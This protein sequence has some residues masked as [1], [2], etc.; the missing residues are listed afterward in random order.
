MTENSSVG[1]TAELVGVS[2]VMPV[3][4]DV[5][6]VKAAVMSLLEQDYAGPFEVAIAVGPSIDGTNEL[7]DELSRADPRIRVI[8]NPVGSTPAG[9]NIAIGATTYPIVVR[10][11]AH[12]VLPRDYARIAVEAITRTGAD[13]V[14]GIMDAQG[15]TASRSASAERRTTSAAPRVQRTPYTSVCSAASRSSVSACSTSASNVARTGNSTDASVPPAVSS[16]SPLSFGS[17]TGHVPGSRHS[18]AS[19]SRPGCG[20]VS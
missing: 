20:A 19:S 3:L 2:Y 7:V 14:G 10:V 4:N 17:P 1:G 8:P 15:T 6:H 9:L 13:N 16:G 12:S 5:T 18:R 11:D